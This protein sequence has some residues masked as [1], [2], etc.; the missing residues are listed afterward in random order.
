MPAWL[1]SMVMRVIAYG[2]DVN[3][4]KARFLKAGVL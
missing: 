3:A 2:E 4:L 1:R